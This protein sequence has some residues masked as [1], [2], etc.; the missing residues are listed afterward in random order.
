M[1][2]LADFTRLARQSSRPV[3]LLEGRRAIPPDQAVLATRLGRLLAEHLPE[4][5]F[6]SGNAEGSDFAFVEGVRLVDPARIELVLPH[7]THGRRRWIDGATMASPEELSSVQERAVMESTIAATPKNRGLLDRRG[8]HKSLAAKAA[9]LIRDTMKV[10]GLGDRLQPATAALF[11]VDPADPE[12]GGTGHTIRVC[13]RHG[14][15]VFFQDHW[16]TWLP[17]LP[18]VTYQSP[19]SGATGRAA[20]GRSTTR[21]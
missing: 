4:A 3:I 20:G 17:G 9:Y 1:T 5:R 10:T 16:I 21:E 2:S 8:S 19:G 18:P 14:V 15:P 12:A 13:R 7:A 6:R 11:W